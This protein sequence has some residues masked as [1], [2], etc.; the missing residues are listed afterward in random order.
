MACRKKKLPST[1]KN[2]V[3]FFD[4]RKQK[5]GDVVGKVFLRSP[6]ARECLSVKK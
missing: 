3:R 4:N 6:V 1:K 5:L 2:R